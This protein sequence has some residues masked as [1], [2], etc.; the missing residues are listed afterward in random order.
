MQNGRVERAAKT[1]KFSGMPYRVAQTTHNATITA[2]PHRSLPR[3]GFVA[4]LG[5]TWAMLMIPAI[6]LLGTVAL[7]GLLP[8]MLIA[9]GLTWYFLERSYKDGDIL[10]T[11]ILTHETAKLRRHNPRSPQQNWQANIHWVVM[12]LTPKDAPVDNY[13]TLQGNGRRVE[14]GAFLTP[15]ERLALSEEMSL[16]LVRFK[17]APGGSR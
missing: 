3:R 17:S 13:L 9:L 10:E 4:F 16:L 11:L 5:V 14:F 6:G 1:T 12:G 15:D 2:W 7:W 8:F